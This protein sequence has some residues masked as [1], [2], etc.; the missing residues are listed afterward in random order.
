VLLT[1]IFCSRNL[2]I[3]KDNKKALIKDG[4][5]EVLAP[6]VALD[7][8]TAA[9]VIFKL[10]GV[11]RQLSDG[12]PAVALSLGNDAKLVAQLVDWSHAA[13]CPWVASEALRLLCSLII[14]SK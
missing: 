6:L 2:A 3:A 14:R 1:T 9:P 13:L 12:V 5:L 7:I 4:V 11:W 10:V 8:R